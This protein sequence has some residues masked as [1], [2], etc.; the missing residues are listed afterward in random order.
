M[1]PAEARPTG[2]RARAPWGVGRAHAESPGRRGG[3]QAPFLGAGREEVSRPEPGGVRMD[4]RGQ[5]VV[6]W[7]AGAPPAQPGALCPCHG[8]GPPR[9]GSAPSHREKT[10]AGTQGGQA[11]VWALWLIASHAPGEPSFSDPTPLVLRLLPRSVG[12]LAGAHW[13][14]PESRRGPCDCWVALGAAVHARWRPPGGV[15][16]HKV[17]LGASSRKRAARRG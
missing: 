11:S 1:A 10:A 16:G 15:V 9:P 14:H 4:G 2:P 17:S 13:R 3:R 8:G 12:G 5:R 6:L 7:A